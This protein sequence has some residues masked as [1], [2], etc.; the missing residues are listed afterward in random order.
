MLRELGLRNFKAYGGKE[1]TAP[2]S[3]INLIFGP[4]SAGKSSILQALLLLKQSLNSEVQSSIGAESIPGSL[5]LNGEDV[6]FESASTLHYNRDETRKLGIRVRFSQERLPA[7]FEAELGFSLTAVNNT[8]LKLSVLTKVAYR[9][10]DKQHIFLNMELRRKISELDWVIPDPVAIAGSIENHLEPVRGEWGV[11]ESFLPCVSLPELNGF[12]IEVRDKIENEYPA[13]LKFKGTGDRRKLLD[14]HFTMRILI[15]NI[16]EA[17]KRARMIMNPYDWDLITERKWETQQEEWS[18]ECERKGQLQNFRELF[19]NVQLAILTPEN[20]PKYCKDTMA[21]ITYLGPLRQHPQR[22]YQN[23]SKTKKSVGKQGEF[24]HQLLLDDSERILEVNKWF[25]RF[26]IPYF[27]GVDLDQS[28]STTSI[29]LV[30]RR[31][32]TIVSLP[33]VGFGVNQ[34]LP[35][36]VEGIVGAGSI[37]CVEQP[38]IHLHPKLQAHLADLMIETC[39]IEEGGFKIEGARVKQWIVETHSELLIMR[40]LRRIREGRISHEDISILYVDPNNSDVEGSV[41]EQLELDE[42]GIF[43]N[44]WPDGFFDEDLSELW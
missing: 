4:N 24:T 18:R 30:D 36:I 27:L 28:G 20:I 11:V 1:Q 44:G 35:V 33:D 40:L 3:R 22:R 21:S 42:K 15:H 12:R 5:E 6:N 8:E 9:I 29:N 31:S 19:S 23:T 2:L 7:V 16:N 14:A 26:E 34:L 43:I 39:C 17:L 10:L 41:I 25:D 37:L 32:K 13:I 38:E